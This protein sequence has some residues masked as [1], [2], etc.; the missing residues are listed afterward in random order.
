MP[1]QALLG[2]AAALALSV[3]PVAVPDGPG[4]G[5]PVWYWPSS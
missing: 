3:G 1:K 5:R 2:T 4:I